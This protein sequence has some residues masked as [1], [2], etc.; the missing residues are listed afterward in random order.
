MRGKHRGA[1]ATG[2]TRAGGGYGPDDVGTSLAEREP[3]SLSELVVRLALAH[4]RFAAGVRRSLGLGAADY[5]ALQELQAAGPLPVGELAA[6]IGLSRPAAT[7][8]VD[9]LARQGRIE[10]RPDEADRRRVIVLPSATAGGLDGE[11]V[12]ALAAEIDAL[13]DGLSVS[14]RGVVAR[15]LSQVADAVERHA[16]EAAGSA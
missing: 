11:R 5:A 2:S 12:G 4:G 9:R 13:G 8:L 3:S 14:E 10:R 16:G 6:R 15:Y 7:A 1:P